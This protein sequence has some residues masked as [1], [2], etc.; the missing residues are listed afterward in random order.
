MH[1]VF[2]SYSQHIYESVLSEWKEKTH[3][4]HRKKNE[5]KGMGENVG[6]VL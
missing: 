4:K 3:T 5:K 2:G 6:D 1:T